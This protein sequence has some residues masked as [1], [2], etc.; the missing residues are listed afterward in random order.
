ML[1]EKAYCRL[2]VLRGVLSLPKPQKCKKIGLSR[3]NENGCVLGLQKAAFTRHCYMEAQVST[4]D[5]RLFDHG[6]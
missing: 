4:A 6:E 5:F 2:H 1:Y 3:S